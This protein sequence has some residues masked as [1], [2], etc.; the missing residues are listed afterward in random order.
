MIKF[1]NVYK[2]SLSVAYSTQEKAESHRAA[3][4]QTRVIFIT[5]SGLIK[6]I[7]KEYES[8]KKDVEIEK[9]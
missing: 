2:G 7:T 1:I 9:E 8:F 5:E 4:S 3:E 6:D